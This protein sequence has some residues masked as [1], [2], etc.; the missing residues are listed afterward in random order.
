MVEPISRSQKKK[1]T[2]ELQE[3]G[4]RL[5]ALSPQQLETL[6]IPDELTQAIRFART[7]NSHGAFRRQCQYIGTL[8]R[9]VDPEPILDALRNF[10]LGDYKKKAAFKTVER[11]RDDLILGDETVL[12]EICRQYTHADRQRLTQL[13]RNAGKEAA[14]GKPPRAAK[15]LFRYLHEIIAFG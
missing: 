2:R 5:L 4:E 11:W 10:E 8:M 1:A 9:R 7:I 13:A 15:N 14:A 6:D 12:E 3:L